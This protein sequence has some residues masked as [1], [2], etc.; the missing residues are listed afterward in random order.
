M[1]VHSVRI[2]NFRR[3]RSFSLSFDEESGNPRPL[4]VIVGPNMSGK[5][6][7]LDSLHIAYEAMA[8]PSRVQFRPGLKADDPSLRPDPTQPIRIDLTF[9]L[10]A[11]EHQTAVELADLVRQPQLIPPLAERYV[12]KLR[13]PPAERQKREWTDRWSSAVWG[14]EP[15]DSHL[16]LRARRLANEA[17]TQRVAG[18]AFLER[19]GGMLYLHQ[20]RTAHLATPSV[21]TGSEQRLRARASRSDLIPWLELQSRLHEKWDIASQGESPWSRVRRL[22]AQLA[23]PARLDDLEAGREGFDLRFASDG[24]RYYASGLSGGERQLLR[25]V[26]NLAAYPA[27]RSVVLVDELELHLHPQW[28]RNLLHFCR[29]GGGDENQFI[30]TTHSESIVRYSAP[31]DVVQLASLEGT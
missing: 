23:T 10:D 5:T 13:W 17:I 28:Q 22:F 25:F 18:E 19:I 9:S 16:A 8:D 1:R 21:A 29:R 20:D 12:A 27:R 6:T 2:D 3:L 26:V 15:T 30:V 31:Q 4:T 7:I 24:T 11:I 14:G